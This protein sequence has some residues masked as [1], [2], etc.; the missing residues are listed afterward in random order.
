MDIDTVL[1]QEMWTITCPCEASFKMT[2]KR[3]LSLQEI[4]CPNC[5]AFIPIAPMQSAI[6]NKMATMKDMMMATTG[7]N[8][9]WGL[10]SES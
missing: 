4:R 5:Q 10:T 1:Q 3:I 8:T 2:A 9:G 7:P 6:K